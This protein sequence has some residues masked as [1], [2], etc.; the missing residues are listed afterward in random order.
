MS[1]IKIVYGS[2]GGNTELVCEWVADVLS[3][4]HNVEL[5]K[6]K[7]TNPALLGDYDLLIL[8]SPTYGHGQ[9]EEYFAEFLEKLQKE[10]LQGRRCAVI[11]LGD[12][13]YD[14]D[15]HLESV[16]IITEFLKEKEADMVGIPLRISKNPLSRLNKYVNNWAKNLSNLI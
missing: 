8:A 16:K 13:K 6:A 15:Y 11:G 1:N 2:C 4:K 9:L 12:P 3:K 10:D 14:S 7:L 5:K